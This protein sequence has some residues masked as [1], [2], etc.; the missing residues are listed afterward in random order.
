MKIGLC[1]TQ[2]TGKTTILKEFQKIHPEFKVVT[3]IARKCIE[4]GLPINEKTTGESQTFILHEQIKA[5]IE[6]YPHDQ[7][8]DRTTLD[9]YAY[10]EMGFRRGN[11]SFAQKEKLETITK[12]WAKSYDKI[13]YIPIE[14]PV[15]PDGVRSVDEEFRRNIDYLIFSE[16]HNY[17]NVITLKGTVE[18]R[19]N[20]IEKFLR[21][22]GF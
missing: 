21:N 20:I 6:N 1:G 14:F 4:K 15:I 11:I 9:Q 16:L 22:R 5:E 18:Q 19:M 8:S 2:G 17:N 13:L 3:E 12:A 7:I 10:I